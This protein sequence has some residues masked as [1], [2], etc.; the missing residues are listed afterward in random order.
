M[1]ICVLG[2]NIFWAEGYDRF[3]RRDAVSG[4]CTKF[5]TPTLPVGVN[6]MPWLAHER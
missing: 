5:P 2:G 6:Q 3:V 4:S 1:H